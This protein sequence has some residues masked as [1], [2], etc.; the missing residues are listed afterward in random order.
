MK[1]KPAEAPA[2]AA[3]GPPPPVQG[4]EEDLLILSDGEQVDGGAEP[5]MNRAL[6]ESQ[7]S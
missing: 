7:V 2:A 4:E 6:E 5:A 1:R 3:P